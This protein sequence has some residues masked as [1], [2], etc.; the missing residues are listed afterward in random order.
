MPNPNDPIPCKTAPTRRLPGRV[1]WDSRGRKVDHF[2]LR[3]EDISLP[4]IARRLSR[5]HRFASASPWTVAEHCLAAAAWAE[6]ADLPES[7]LRCALLHDAAEAWLGDVPS[8]LKKRLRFA[9]CSYAAAE[10]KILGVVARKYGWPRPPIALLG[11]CRNPAQIP[12]QI[13]TIDRRLKD[14]EE[15]YQFGRLTA[16]TR[17][18]FLALLDPHGLRRAQDPPSEAL[19]VEQFLQRAAELGMTD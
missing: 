3:P 13:D 16:L 17:I 9:D 7:Y 8:P 6:A 2:D 15:A 18:R 19:I 4:E 5:I 1:F 10:M 11:L 14:I 12:Q